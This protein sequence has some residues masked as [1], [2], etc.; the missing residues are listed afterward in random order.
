M[1]MSNNEDQRTIPVVSGKSSPRD[2]Y[3]IIYTFNIFTLLL[4][5]LED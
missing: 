4:L 3:I 2:D 5:F 1:T